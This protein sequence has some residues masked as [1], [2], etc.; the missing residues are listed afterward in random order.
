MLTRRTLTKGFLGGIAAALGVSQVAKAETLPMNGG[1]FAEDEIVT[2]PMPESWRGKTVEQI[3][4]PEWGEGT[5][6]AN[7]EEYFASI[8]EPELEVIEVAPDPFMIQ[9]SVREIIK[10]FHWEYTDEHGTAF[11]LEELART[12]DARDFILVAY[13][14]IARE[15]MMSP[16]ASIA[17]LIVIP[18]FH[19]AYNPDVSVKD[20]LSSHIGPFVRMVHAVEKDGQLLT[21]KQVRAGE[22]LANYVSSEIKTQMG[23]FL[24]FERI[25]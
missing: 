23:F 7:A 13:P 21:E 24:P 12:R 17:S 15:G 6:Y 4:F 25:I 11:K 3:V 9:E 18:A 20:Y 14:Y 8:E 10:E 1:W 22:K 2:M 16:Y 5:P 19:M